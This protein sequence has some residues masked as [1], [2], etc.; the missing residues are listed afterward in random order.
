MDVMEPSAFY[1][2]SDNYSDVWEYLRSTRWNPPGAADSASERRRTYAFALEQAEQMLRAAVTVGPATRPLLIF[3][4]LN[5]AGRAI[6]ASATSFGSNDWRLQGHGIHVAPDSLSGDLSAIQVY[7]DKSGSKGSFVRLSEVFGSPVWE[8]SLGVTLSTL[9]DCVPKNRLT[10]IGVDDR[11]RR[12]PLYVADYHVSDDDDPHPL[13]SVP[14]AYFPPWVIDASDG[15]RAMVEYLNEFPDAQGYDSYHR[16]TLPP[17]ALPEFVR[18]ADGW[19]ELTMNWSVMGGA[20]A[21]AAEGRLYLKERTR[22]HAGNEYFFPT[23][24]SGGR[25]IHPL[26]AW[27]AVLFVLSMLARY[28]PSEWSEH[29]D[30]NHSRHAAPIEGLL[31]DALESLPYL[32]A[33]AIDQ[34]SGQS[35]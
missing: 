2:Y 1:P 20:M 16:K 3:Y 15:H 29:I 6:A 5:Q 35:D 28:Q 18:H 22:Q 24:G 11:S 13:V 19:G 7:P 9:W 26:M 10:P 34:V 31:K 32:I 21:T 33:E 27:W 12:T 4:G 14:V 17:N 25:G 30:V 23:I 8:K